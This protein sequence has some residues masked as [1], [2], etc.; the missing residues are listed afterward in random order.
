MEAFPFLVETSGFQDNRP[1]RDC[2]L[3]I[4]RHHHDACRC[5][6]FDR[7]SFD[8][9]RKKICWFLGY[10]I[11]PLLLGCSSKEK[12]VPSDIS[13]PAIKDETYEQ[14]P[15]SSQEPTLNLD[16]LKANSISNTQH[17]GCSGINLSVN[18]YYDAGYEQGHED[19]Y[20]DGV[21]NLRGDSYDDACRYKGKKR[22]EYE[23][24]YEEGYEAGFDDGFAYSDYDSEDEE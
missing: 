8:M 6:P 5:V 24:G 22:K 17:N 2:W 15:Q 4:D 14:A 10:A 7:E 23:L 19:G 20:N 12:N 16:S 11:M 18:P 1:L 9:V 3:V 13:T 21:E